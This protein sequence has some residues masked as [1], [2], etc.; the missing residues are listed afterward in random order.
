MASREIILRA[1]DLI[2][3]EVQALLGEDLV[4]KAQQKGAKIRITVVS[5]FPKLQKT[6]KPRI[7]IDESFLSRLQSL[8]AKP[9]MLDREVE[10]LSKAQLLR[11]AELSG[12]PMSKSAKVESLRAQLIHSLRSTEIWRGISGEND[13]SATAEDN[14]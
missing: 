7:E 14:R 1:G 13:E 12:L 4:Q 11:V 3:Q 10:H 5:P 9:E 6:P 2:S 8:A